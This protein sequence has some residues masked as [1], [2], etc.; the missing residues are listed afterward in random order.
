MTFK[1]R[2]KLHYQIET[3]SVEKTFFPANRL[4]M[5]Q[6]E[7]Q[8]AERAPRRY[9]QVFE[10][11]RGVEYMTDSWTGTQLRVRQNE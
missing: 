11:A 10:G 1:G 7:P 4:R 6:V 9:G 8:G 3:A 2:G 5:N